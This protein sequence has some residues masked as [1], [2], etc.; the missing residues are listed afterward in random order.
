MTFFYDLNKKLDTIREKPETTH[1]QLNERDMSRAAKGYE[2]YG[3]A[4]MEALAK[5]GREGKSLDPVR[6]KYDKY[7]DSV[8]EA[9][10]DYSAKK[11]RAGKDIGKPGKNFEKIAKGAAERYGSKAAG[12]RVAGAVLNKLRHPKE[13]ME[14]GLGDAVKK[15]GGMAKK[16]GGAVLN[17]LGHGDDEAMRKDLQRKMGV[18]QTGKKPGVKEG[19]FGPMEGGAPMTA[20]QKSFAKL[21][22]PADKITFADKIAGAKKEVDEMLGDVAAEAIKG[23]LTGKQKKLDKNNNGKLDANDFAML[24][25]GGKQVADEGWDEMEKDVKSRMGA[26]RVGDVTHGAKHDTQEIPGG[27][28]VTRRTDP[29]T[30]YSIGADSDEPA[31]GEKRGRGRPK[32]ASGPRQERVTAKSRKTDRTAYSKK[33]TNEDDLDITDRGEYDQEGEMAKDDIK[34]IVRHAQALQ[35]VLGDN[36]N[37]PEWVQAKLA[38]IEGMMTAVDDYMQNQADD[39]EMAVGEEK[40][41]TRD[42]RAERA[43]KKVTKDIEY[44]EKKKDGIHGAKRGSEDAKAEKAGKKVAKD[45][46]HDEK[47]SK[48]KEKTEEQGGTGT[49]T[50]SSGFSFGQGIYDSM[51]RELESMIAES[52]N[53]S[54]SM[55]TDAN[56]GPSKSITVTATDDDAMKLGELLKNAGLGGDHDM[57]HGAAE[58]EVHGAED[59][60]DKIRQAMGDHEHA[61]GETCDACGQADCGCEEMDESYGDDVVSQNSPDFPSNTE[62]SHDAFQYSGGLNKPKAS[63]MATIPVTDVVADGEDNFGKPARTNE[64]DLARLREMAGIK[65]AKKDVEEEKTEEGNLFTGNLAKARAD[66]KKEADLDGDG[67]MEKVRES[68]LDLKHLWSQYKG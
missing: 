42:N 53:V 38:K 44:D 13:G 6:A 1:K 67:D 56:G 37:L 23:A 49:P 65:E 39:E 51:N 5:A 55:N 8:E 25:K 15:V 14:E 32:S 19:D 28:R 4:G 48:K 3:K 10:G 40:T 52:M 7:K 59:I 45:I 57:G 11:A 24:R 26:R 9:S 27:R 61:E 66:G 46:E 29:N 68:I 41:T 17:K 2:K 54:M 36:D 18:P 33:K 31:A 16:V 50:A 58:L 34:T 64:D 47:K 60:A 43:G 63:G 62:T 30:G 35:K 20:K 12:E 21:A 22:P